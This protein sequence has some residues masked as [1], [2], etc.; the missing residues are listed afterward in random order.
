MKRL[1][2]SLVAVALCTAITDG[3]FDAPYAQDPTCTFRMVN[4]V[5]L[6]DNL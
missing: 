2:P 4:G 6:E 3:T 5:V 1:A